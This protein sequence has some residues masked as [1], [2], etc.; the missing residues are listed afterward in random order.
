MQQ[1]SV[2]LASGSDPKGG[3]LFVVDAAGVEVI[4]RLTTRGLAVHDDELYRVLTCDNH[5]MPASDLFVYDAT[6]IRESYRLDGVWDAHDVLVRHEDVLVV[7]SGDDVVYAVE[8]DGA[9]RRWWAADPPDGARHVNCVNIEHGE[10]VA[11][12]FGHWNRNLDATSGRLMRLPSQEVI[13]DGLSMPHTPRLL[14]GSWI[15]C[16]SRTRALQAYDARGT[17]LR[18]V[19]LDGFT[20]GLAYDAHYLY[21]GVSAERIA[22]PESLGTASIAILDRATWQLLGT[23]ALPTSNVYDVVLAPR[24]LL[25]GLRDGFQ[26]DA[27]FAADHARSVLRAGVAIAPIWAIADPLPTDALG[28]TIELEPPRGMRP[29]EIV[30]LRCRVTNTGTA[31]YMSAPPN[32]VELCY[33]WYDASG[34]T[35]DA[36]RWL[37]SPLPKPLAP[38]ERVD[39]AMRIAAPVRPGTYTLAITLLQADVAWFDDLSPAF[40]VRRDVSVADDPLGV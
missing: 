27:E 29:R 2:L 39:A 3:G 11:T 36:G 12:E 5:A 20:R 22:G 14:D 6:G 7:S 15:V 8:K 31:T 23:I 16:N 17:L 38:G 1:D 30:T 26:R 37:H 24:A 32:P 21:L 19:T 13:I 4:D 10:V 9:L 28:A 40:G 35:V 33:R 34:A 18:E 25:P